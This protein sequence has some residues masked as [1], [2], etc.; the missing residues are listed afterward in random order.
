[1]DANI[2][3]EKCLTLTSRD[4]CA[5]SYE[6]DGTCLHVAPRHECCDDV[7]DWWEEHSKDNGRVTFVPKGDDASADDYLVCH[8]ETEAVALITQLQQELNRSLV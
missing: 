6:K 3:L 2:A 8:D 7:H 4:F 5:E 1:M